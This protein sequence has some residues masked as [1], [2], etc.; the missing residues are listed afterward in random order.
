VAVLHLSVTWVAF[1]HAFMSRCFFYFYF[2]LLL[3]FFFHDRLGTKFAV[4]PYVL[5]ARLGYK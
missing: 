2:I 4:Y 5:K 3:L 1:L